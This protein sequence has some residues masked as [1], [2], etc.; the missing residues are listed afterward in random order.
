MSRGLL[1]LLGLT[2]GLLAMRADHAA[3]AQQIG[4]LA[5]STDPF[6]ALVGERR[7]RRKSR[8]ARVS[9]ERYVLASD[10][11]AFL[12][13]DRTTEARVKFLCGPDD[14]RI[15]CLI[16][17]ERPAP[18]IYQL[19]ATRGPRGDVIYKNSE[20]D[21]FLRIA[22]YGGAT[23]FWPGEDRGF[24]ASKSFGD[25]QALVLRRASFMTA[26]HRAQSATAMVSAVT[27]APIV[28]EVQPVIVGARN[29]AALTDQAD[30][31][32]VLADA[33][34]RTAKGINKVARDPT[35][36]RII[37]SKVQ[38]VRFIV[39]PAPDMALEEG[40]LTVFYSPDKDINGRLSSAAVARFLEDTL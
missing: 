5:Q 1:L 34:V 13:E 9:V 31:A 15:D 11:R 36:A 26:Q 17:Q 25:D 30:D 20:G 24:A 21:V 29:V 4:P 14:E 16:D 2:A 33:V 32:T 35:G 37:A 8:A 28:F 18:E 38:K 23:V 39:G 10:D 22:S 7:E 3:H 27:G 40:V 6:S 19:N 12:F